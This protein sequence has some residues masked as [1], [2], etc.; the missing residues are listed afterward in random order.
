[1]TP[2]D[3]DAR[4]PFSSYSSPESSRTGDVVNVALHTRNPA[5]SALLGA[6][7]AMAVLGVLLIRTPARAQ[8]A[9]PA[10]HDDAAFDFMNLLDH[11]G[12]H[13]ISDESWNAYGQLTFIS[14]WKP[15]FSAGYT[16]LHGSTN[17]LLPSAEQSFTGTFTLFFGLRLWKGAEAYVVPEVINERPFSGLKGLGGAIQNFE[18]QKTGSET[19]QLYRSRTYMRQ[20]IGLGGGTLDKSSDPMQLGARVDKRRIVLT[21]GNFTILDMFDRNSVSSDP[22][23]T[24]INM[25]FMT[26]ASWDFPSDARGYSWGGVAELYWDNWEA[27]FGR[28]TPPVNPNQLPLDFRF[29]E[30]YGDQ[31]EVVHKHTIA[32]REGAIRLLGYRNRVDTGRFSDAISAFLR[33][34]LENAGDCP[35]TVFNYGSGNFNAPDLCWVRKTNVKLGVGV[36]VE[37]RLTENLGVFARGMYSDGQTEVDAFNAADRS[38][39]AGAVAKG[40]MWRRPFDLA[41]VG[42][43]MSWISAV[44]AQYL[45][46]G[47]IDGFIGDGALRQ[48]GEGV[49]E[50]FYSFN[51]LKAIWLSGDYQF[52]W[53]PGYNADRGPLHVFGVRVHA[54][55]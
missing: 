30:Y 40:P 39:N 9:P 18:L 2:A 48:A 49:V 3:T 46:L 21:L 19:P 31:L 13:D 22:R 16:N 50:A 45:A 41:G 11:R 38:F 24:F 36:N 14:S 27:R 4:A 26:H 7:A 43:G 28:I 1:V 23:Q 37:Q 10:G 5:R 33:N 55:F 6:L 29:W 52:I 44:H 42:F 32:G 47:G 15:A 25:A 12:L 17:S 8:A 51:L 53:N 54:E 34:P 20:T 35:A